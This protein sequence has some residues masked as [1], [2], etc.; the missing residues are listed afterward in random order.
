M[1]ENL[2]C[3]LNA[4]LEENLQTNSNTIQQEG[5]CLKTSMCAWCVLAWCSDV[6]LCVYSLLDASVAEE[7]IE[8]EYYQEEEYPGHFANQGKPSF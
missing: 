7:D 5:Y 1:I 6:V 4:N 2:T 8:G 3:T